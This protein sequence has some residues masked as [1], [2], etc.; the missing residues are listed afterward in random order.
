MSDPEYQK[1]NNPIAGLTFII[2]WITILFSM[3]CSCLGMTYYFM[4]VWLGW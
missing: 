2:F 1:G 3:I 4:R